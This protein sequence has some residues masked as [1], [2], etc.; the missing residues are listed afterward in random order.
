MSTVPNLEQILKKN[1]FQIYFSK[2]GNI[3]Q[4]YKTFKRLLKVTNKVFNKQD[5]MAVEV[6]MLKKKLKTWDHIA[7]EVAM[8]KK[9]VKK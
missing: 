2:S 7:T 4:A 9:K 3:C 6:A 8:L 5:H 1:V